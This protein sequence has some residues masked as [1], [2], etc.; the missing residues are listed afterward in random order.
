MLF[1]H[2]IVYEQLHLKLKEELIL[3]KN[4]TIYLALNANN[5]QL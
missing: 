2:K 3:L 5:Y 4:Y 1:E